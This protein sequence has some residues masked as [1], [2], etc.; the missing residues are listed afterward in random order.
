[1]TK[2]VLDI[3]RGRRGFEGGIQ[4]GRRI[5]HH[6]WILRLSGQRQGA[7]MPASLS[8]QI[9]LAQT[10]VFSSHTGSRHEEGRELNL[11]WVIIQ[12]NSAAETGR[13]GREL[14]I[15]TEEQ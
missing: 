3:L 1:M 11:T 4:E 2:E 9:Q 13:D 15:R 8:L 5:M 7:P 14:G 10:C 6:E 12:P